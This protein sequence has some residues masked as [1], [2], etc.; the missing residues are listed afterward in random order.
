MRIERYQSGS[1]RGNSGCGCG[2]ITMGGGI[3]L[4]IVMVLIAPALPAF[5]LRLAGFQAIEKP[6][7]QSTPEAIPLINSAQGASQVILSAGSYGQEII[8]QSS[9][10]TMQ[11]GT[12]E[13]NNGIAQIATTESGIL[14]ICAQYTD[15]CTTTGDKFRNVAVNLQNNRTAISGEAYIPSLNTWQALSVIV[16]VTADNAII[17]D[18][19]EVN[20]TLFGIPDG[21][22]GQQLRDLQTGANEALRQLTLQSNGT[23][24]RLSD[25]T[26]TETQL[27]AS[28]R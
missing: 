21:E 1:R 9:A 11:I 4:A 7:T 5:G 6:I 10:Y 20:G 24:Y 17:I 2:L 13:N 23:S 16:S 3:I 25:I 22:L 14:S 19:V 26:I 27:V 15:L 12:D 8:S 18:G 28:F